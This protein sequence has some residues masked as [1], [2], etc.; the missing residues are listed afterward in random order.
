M[1]AC[2]EV[3]ICE[4]GIVFDCTLAG[5]ARID[6]WGWDCSDLGVRGIPGRGR[7]YDGLKKTHL[8]AC[9]EEEH[10]WVFLGAVGHLTSRFHDEEAEAF[11]RTGNFQMY[12]TL[13][14]VHIRLSHKITRSFSV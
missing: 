14:L 5:A 3:R 9:R 8:A 6:S 1:C 4:V 12:D 11:P 13:V 10:C 7:N 2:R